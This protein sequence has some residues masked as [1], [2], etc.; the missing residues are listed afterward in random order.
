M[1]DLPI[2]NIELTYLEARVELIKDEFFRSPSGH[3]VKWYKLD[4]TYASWY[5][6]YRLNQTNFKRLAYFLGEIFGPDT[7]GYLALLEFFEIGSGQVK[8]R[9]TNGVKIHAAVGGNKGPIPA[10]VLH[11]FLKWFFEKFGG[12]NEGKA[13]SGQADTAAREPAGGNRK[14]T[15]EE[16]MKA[17]QFYD[18]VNELKQKTTIQTACQRVGIS[19]STYYNYKRR[20]E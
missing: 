1:D 14:W 6:L 4:E 5:N 19:K 15:D 11:Q 3:R 13:L 9:V 20:F 2:L 16:E 10:P 18:K 12:I 17:R 8:P 7:G